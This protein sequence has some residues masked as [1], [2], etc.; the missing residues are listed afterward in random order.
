M[1][2]TATIAILVVA[3][4]LFAFGS[5]R[6]AQPANPL[7]PRLIPWRLVMILSGAVAILMLAHVANLFGIQTGSRTGM[8]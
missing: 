2:L 5:W 8:R 6:S 4:A 3:A 7:K 1:D